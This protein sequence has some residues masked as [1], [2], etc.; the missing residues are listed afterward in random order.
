MYSFKPLRADNKDVWLETAER[1]DY[2]PLNAFDEP[3]LD[4]QLKTNCAAGAILYKGNKAVALLPGEILE[5]KMTPASLRVVRSRFGGILVTNDNVSDILALRDFVFQKVLP[6]YY[7]KELKADYIDV[8]LPPKIMLEKPSCAHGL[9]PFYHGD[10]EI[11]SILY[12]K[13]EDDLLGKLKYNNARRHIKKGLEN[14]EKLK[15]INSDGKDLFRHLSELEGAKAT[16]LKI[17]GMPAHYLKRML[18]SQFYH[19]LVAVSDDKPLSAVIY[20]C[21]NSIGTLR[22]NASSE[23]GKRLFINKGLLFLAM[24]D[25]RARGADYFLLGS[26]WEHP[27]DGSTK[28][29]LQQLA[30][31]KRCFSTDE[32]TTYRFQYPLTFKGALALGA[33]QMKKKR[34]FEED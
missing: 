6:D 22:Y 25:C 19:T 4:I 20:T 23:E 32:A 17:R 9:L 16:S 8:V 1:C 33:N 30:F 5:K 11:N 27:M 13:L 31:F 24:Q 18:S 2:A 10:V 14:I 15:I 21:F 26:G 7:S 29:Q 12:V 3:L 34:F 28:N